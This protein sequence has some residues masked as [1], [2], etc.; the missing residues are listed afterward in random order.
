MPHLDTK[1]RQ[2]TWARIDRHLSIGALENRRCNRLLTGGCH[3]VDPRERRNTVLMPWMVAPGSIS[4]RQSD[5]RRRPRHQANGLAKLLHFLIR[6][7]KKVLARLPAPDVDRTRPSAT[8]VLHSPKNDLLKHRAQFREKPV[9]ND[10]LHATAPR[11]LRWRT[12]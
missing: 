3:V 8:V 9:V 1:N 6:P 2:P 7:L 11:N 4:H 10:R 12:C 5:K